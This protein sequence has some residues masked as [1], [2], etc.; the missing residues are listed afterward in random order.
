M[1]A[2]YLTK[3]GLSDPFDGLEVGERPGPPAREGWEIISV[4]AA[5]ANPHDLW[6]LRGVVGVPIEPPLIL[7]CDGAG[8]DSRGREV[9]IHSVVSTGEKFRMLT[10]GVD[11]TFAAKVAIPAGHTV[12]KPP[13]LSFEEAAGLGTAWLTAWRMLFTKARLLPGERLL[14]QGG[15]GGVATA[16]IILG[17]AAGAHVTVTS[18][19]P[20]MLE[21]VLAIGAHEAV[22]TGSRLSERVDVVIETVGAPTWSHSLASLRYGGRIVV[23]GAT[24]GHEVT[25][26]LRRVFFREVSVLGSTMGTLDELKALCAFVTQAELRPPVEQ[27]YEGIERVPDALRALDE[28]KVFGKVAVKI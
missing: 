26:D 12:P 6:T 21:R 8:I 17:S 25:S 22:S 14:V 28:G 3:L 24:A 15:G 23:A 16:A 5:T 7:G 18:R 27:V 2:A 13:H 9:V 20:E 4:K 19:R 10:D 11:G 1:L